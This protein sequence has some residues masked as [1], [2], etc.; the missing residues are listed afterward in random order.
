VGVSDFA[1]LVLENK[2]RDLEERLALAEARI[3][4]MEPKQTSI[5]ISAGAF[6]NESSRARQEAVRA[7]AERSK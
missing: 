2:A 3:A 1:L 4:E 7:I 5:V 6:A